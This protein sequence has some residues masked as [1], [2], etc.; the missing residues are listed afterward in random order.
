M[1]KAYSISSKLRH[2]WRA[3]S[4]PISPR[5]N[6]KSGGRTVKK[7]NCAIFPRIAQWHNWPAQFE[8]FI[9]RIHLN[10][11]ASIKE[12]G[13][14]NKIAVTIPEA[15]AMSGIGR[16][17]LYTLFKTGSLTPR[18]N[19]KRTLVLVEDLE[20]YVKNLPMAG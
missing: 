10:T 4:G 12:F 13:T 11:G 3:P 19:G 6:G 9:L 8:R 15:V 5:L 18:K 2:H 16:S 20:R 1:R 7:T 14:L 17:S